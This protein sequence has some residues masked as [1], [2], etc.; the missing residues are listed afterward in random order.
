MAVDIFYEHGIVAPDSIAAE[1]DT[2]VVLTHF[3]ASRERGFRVSK[4]E[5]WTAWVSPGADA[6]TMLVVSLAVAT[7]T[8]AEEA[9]EADPQG[10]VGSA[11]LLAQHQAERPL[12]PI[13]AH[14]CLAGEVLKEHFSITPNWS[15]VEGD[16]MLLH[17]YNPSTLVAF[18]ADAGVLIW[19]MKFY[20]KWLND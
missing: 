8:H 10:G 3:D 7:S 16:S 17:I 4:V 15:I 6:E 1:S 2:G 13:G 20:G 18:P 12:W 19:F 11:D 14:P 5:G 9:I